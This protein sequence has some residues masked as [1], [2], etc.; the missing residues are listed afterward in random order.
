MVHPEIW[1]W[2]KRQHKSIVTAYCADYLSFDKKM[3]DILK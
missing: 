2:L 1:V 3:T